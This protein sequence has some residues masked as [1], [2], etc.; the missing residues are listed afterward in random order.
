MLRGKN[1]MISVENRVECVKGVKDVKGI[2][3]IEKCEVM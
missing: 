3:G 1:R 2:K